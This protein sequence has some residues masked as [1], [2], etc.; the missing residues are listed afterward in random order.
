MPLSSS[1]CAHRE[2]A[3]RCIAGPIRPN[4]PNPPDHE[5][6]DVD[7]PHRLRLYTGGFQRLSNKALLTTLTELSAM[8]A[9][10]ST[11]LR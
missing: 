3:R 6:P 7:G 5:G 4:R 9:P 8:A 1:R 2:T 10:A 11:G